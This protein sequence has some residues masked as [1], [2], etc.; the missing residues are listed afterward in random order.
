MF[1]KKSVL[2]LSLC[3]LLSTSFSDAQITRGRLNHVSSSSEFD[4]VIASGDV[5]VKFSATWCGPCKAMEPLVKA[6]AQD[7]KHITF[8]E[9]DTDQQRDL[10]HRYG[11]RSI[12]T[13]IFLRDGKEVKRLT[14]SM[15]K[16][17]L[18]DELNQIFG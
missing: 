12:P 4:R 13:M 9:I 17:R 11:V 15:S 16:T 14:G 1:L 18:H 7:F 10:M 8:I 2:M 6:A 5:V 3:A